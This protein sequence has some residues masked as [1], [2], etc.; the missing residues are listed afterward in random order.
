MS[1]GKYLK[2]EMRSP[3]RKRVV[4]KLIMEQLVYATQS[5]EQ[6]ALSANNIAQEESSTAVVDL[7]NSPSIDTE[8]QGNRERQWQKEQ[9]EIAW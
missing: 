9:E 7:S 4:Q 6:S 1:L 3:L 2:L 5:F 8:N